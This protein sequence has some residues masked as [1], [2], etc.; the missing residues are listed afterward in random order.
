MSAKSREVL[1]MSLPSLNTTHTTYTNAKQTIQHLTEQLQ[2]EQTVT[3]RLL[4]QLQHQIQTL[5][6]SQ[7]IEGKHQLYLYSRSRRWVYDSDLLSQ[8]FKT[9][10]STLTHVHSHFDVADEF[11]Y[12]IIDNKQF[13][14]VFYVKYTPFVPTPPLIDPS[15][16]LQGLTTFPV[17][18]VY[19]FLKT[20]STSNNEW[21]PLTC[22]HHDLDERVMFFPSNEL[23]LLLQL[24]NPD[25]EGWNAPIVETSNGN[26]NALAVARHLAD[27]MELL[28]W[29]WG[30]P[31]LMHPHSTDFRTVWCKMLSLVMKQVGT[32]WSVHSRHRSSD[33]TTIG[34]LIRPSVSFTLLKKLLFTHKDIAMVLE[35]LFQYSWCWHFDCTEEEWMM[36][37]QLHARDTLRKLQ[38]Y[39]ESYQRQTKL[40]WNAIVTH[41][42]INFVE[43]FLHNDCYPYKIEYAQWAF[44]Y[45]CEKVLK[46]FLDKNYAMTNYVTSSV[47][48]ICAIRV[49]KCYEL[50]LSR[51]LHHL[52]HKFPLLNYVLPALQPTN[53]ASKEEWKTYLSSSTVQSSLQ[54]YPRSKE[55]LTSFYAGKPVFLQDNFEESKRVK[56]ELIQARLL[57]I[58]DTNQ[59]VKEP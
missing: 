17:I 28:V 49:I 4:A 22:F 44:A 18:K 57:V 14:Y 53:Y 1:K 21:L 52:I 48:A 42:D 9:Q 41:D 3:Q 26:C 8:F 6:A 29:Y 33:H 19:S 20:T 12:P 11:V 56:E 47:D 54:Y 34:T 55:M 43:T 16:P 35:V 13:T 58:D 10:S 27:F 36:L 25:K 40:L 32:V 50:L 38:T 31:V 30:P 7:P 46:W 59:I 15:T 24:H 2:H 23:K 5:D 37:S 45:G 39:R 51:G